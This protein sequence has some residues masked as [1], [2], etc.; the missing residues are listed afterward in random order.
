M[1]TSFLVML[2]IDMGAVSILLPY[3]T[4][5]SLN[6]R[7]MSTLVS[8]ALSSRTVVVLVF[9]VPAAD[10]ITEEDLRVVGDGYVLSDVAAV[11][12]AAT[13]VVL[14]HALF[15]VVLSQSR[16]LLTPLLA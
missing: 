16:Q 4:H 11:A 12:T 7:V 13:G 5:A 8:Q 3:L 1:I 14:K 6:L 9:V 15:R 2:P 10:Q